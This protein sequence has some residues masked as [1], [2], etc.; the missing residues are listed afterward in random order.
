VTRSAAAPP[1]RTADR[2][3]VYVCAGVTIGEN[4]I[5]G[6]NSVV[7]RDAL[8]DTVVGGVPARVIPHKS[9]CAAERVER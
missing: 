8:P 1:F 5:V 7:T 9:V 4:R 2:P 6:A 3:H